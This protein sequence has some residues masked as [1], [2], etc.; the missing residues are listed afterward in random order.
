[1]VPSCSGSAWKANLPPWLRHSAL[2]QDVAW[3]SSPSQ[4]KDWI[5]KSQLWEH[6][7]LTFQPSFGIWISFVIGYF[8]IRH[9]FIFYGAL[10][11]TRLN[12]EMPESN[13]SYMRMIPPLP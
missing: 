7:A 8:V 5:I 9:F 10:K 13:L 3:A 2:Q 12:P 6:A 4:S 11:R 1:M